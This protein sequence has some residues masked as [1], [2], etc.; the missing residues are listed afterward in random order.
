MIYENEVF[1]IN[2]KENPLNPHQH[3]GLHPYV[4]I[5]NSGTHCLIAPCTSRTFKRHLPTHIKLT[6]EFKVPS[7]LLVEQMTTVPIK[8]VKKGKYLLS[9]NS[10][11]IT[12]IKKGVEIQFA[13]KDKNISHSSMHGSI[14]SLNGSDKLFLVVSN[15]RCN[16]FS[17]VLHVSPIEDEKVNS[18]EIYLLPKCNLTKHHTAPKELQTF[19]KCYC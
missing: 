8:T 15:E 6:S 11:D 14:C 17:P 3:F 9:L 12:N 13:I 19:K 16:L 18:K 1:L 2:I 4:V 10:T 5:K 7:V